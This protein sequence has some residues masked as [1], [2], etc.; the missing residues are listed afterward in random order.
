MYNI[1]MHIK[2]TTRVSRKFLL[3]LRRLSGKNLEGYY[4][5][6]H[7]SINSIS[8]KKNTISIINPCVN[9]FSNFRQ[10]YLIILFFFSRSQKLKKAC[11][12]PLRTLHCARKRDYYKVSQ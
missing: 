2:F 12:E 5:T 10:N 6:R 11:E 4:L 3:I 9:K 1:F 7:Q 8:T